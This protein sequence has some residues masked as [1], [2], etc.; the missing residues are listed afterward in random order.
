MASNNANPVTNI[1]RY[2]EAIDLIT[3]AL[4]H[5]DGPFS[6]EG[7]HF[8][9][10]H[11]NIWPPPVAAAASA[12]VG[13]DGRS[14]HRER[15]RPAR[16]GQRAGAARRRRGRKRAWAAYRQARAEAGLPHGRRPTTSAYAALVYVGDTHEE[17][18]RVG[19][20]AAVVPQHEPEV[21]AAVLASSCPARCRRPSRRRSIA[22]RRRRAA[23][24]RGN[25]AARATAEQP[26]ASATQNVGTLIG[27]TAEQ[28]MAR[29]ILFAG[30]PDTVYEQIMELLREGRR[31]RPSHHGRPVRLHDAC[32]GGEGHQALLEGSAAAPAGDRARHRRLTG[33][34]RL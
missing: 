31:L 27:I 5:Q 19:E 26:V 15:G 34:R 17:G 14:G 18:V 3:K 20:Q 24:R 33:A 32:G 16:H 22:R 25:G 6:W 12:H 29:G 8:T 2:W 7:K 9:H 23:D 4:T 1:E 28:A 11:V 30:S 21:G 10:R 13:G